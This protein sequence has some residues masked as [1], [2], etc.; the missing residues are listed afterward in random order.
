MMDKALLQYW[1]LWLQQL[2]IIKS[3]SSWFRISPQDHLLSQTLFCEHLSD[4]ILQGM[5][6]TNYTV[7]ERIMWYKR[8]NVMFALANLSLQLCTAPFTLDSKPPLTSG[9]CLRWERVRRSNDS[10]ALMGFYRLQLRSA[11]METWHLGGWL[12][13]NL[14][15][16]VLVLSLTE[17]LK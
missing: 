14:F 10:A 15:P 1:D 12:I 5:N 9:L 16:S 3:W 2:K 11:V 4:H 17:R 7:K 8:D 6:A 13:F